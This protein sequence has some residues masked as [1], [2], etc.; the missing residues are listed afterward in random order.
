MSFHENI[1]KARSNLIFL[2]ALICGL[3]LVTT[4]EKKLAFIFHFS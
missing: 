3:L 1:I 2:A 4:L